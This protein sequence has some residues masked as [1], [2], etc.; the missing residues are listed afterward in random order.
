MGISVAAVT[1]TVRA[2]AIAL[3][4]VPADDTLPG[5]DEIGVHGMEEF[6]PDL[7]GDGGLREGREHRLAQGLDLLRREL[8]RRHR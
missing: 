8:H 4:A 6:G 7:R 3:P 5:A 1:Q 2:F